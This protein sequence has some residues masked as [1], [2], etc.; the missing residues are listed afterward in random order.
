MAEI[1]KTECNVR[2][3]IKRPYDTKGR[4][5]PE[6]FTNHVQKHNLMKNQKQKKTI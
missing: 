3:K 4:R 5:V 2:P 1:K 6:N